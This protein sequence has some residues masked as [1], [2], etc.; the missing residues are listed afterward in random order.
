MKLLTKLLLDLKEEEIEAD[1]E[2][3]E[4]E[5]LPFIMPKSWISIITILKSGMLGS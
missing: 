2:E 5:P 4:N 1:V 3:E